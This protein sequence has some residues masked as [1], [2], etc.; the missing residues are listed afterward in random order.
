MIRLVDEVLTSRLDCPDGLPTRVL[1]SST[2]PWAPVRSSP[3]SSTSSPASSPKEA[4][5][6]FAKSVQELA[7]RLIGFEKQ[8]G[9]FAVAQ[10]RVGQ[11]LR[12]LNARVRLRDMR[13][14]LADTLA[15]PWRRNELFD[16]YGALWGPL[17]D[18]AEAAAPS[19]ATSAS[20]LSSATLPTANR[21]KAR[22]DGSR[23][24][25]E[26]AGPPLWM[27]SGFAVLRVSTKTS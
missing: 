20:P 10:M 5:E 9:A 18:D 11:M 26:A 15:D 25:Q 6:A 4:T 16:R 17:R 14:H 27:P 1:P 7:R 8:M 3:A 22:A 24:V 12:Q 2:R 13:L 23:R 19:S 21:Q